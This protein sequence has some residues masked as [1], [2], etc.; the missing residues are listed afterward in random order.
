MY[1]CGGKRGGW[2]TGARLH[3]PFSERVGVF[4]IRNNPGRFLDR[5]GIA[6]GLMPY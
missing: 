1:W 6:I 4:V 5:A 2:Q 3:V